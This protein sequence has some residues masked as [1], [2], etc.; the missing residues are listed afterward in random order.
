MGAVQRNETLSSLGAGTIATEAKAN[1]DKNLF[2]VNVDKTLAA[3]E[4]P[5]VKFKYR[6]PTGTVSLVEAVV[7]TADSGTAATVNVEIGGTS[8]LTGAISLGATYTSGTIDTGNDDIV[9][10]EDVEVVF[11]AGSVGDADNLTVNIQV[12]TN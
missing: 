8:C 1:Y 12:Q 7:G 5:I 3:S 4:D 6:G 9:D 11:T 2:I 10:G